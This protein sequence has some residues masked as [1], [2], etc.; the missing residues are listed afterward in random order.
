MNLIKVLIKGIE[1]PIQ[2]GNIRL[3]EYKDALSKED[4]TTVEAELN[5]H[6]TVINFVNTLDYRK[7][8]VVLISENGDQF[9]GEFEIHTGKAGMLLVGE[10]NKIKGIVKITAIPFEKR[11]FQSERGQGIA[12]VEELKENRN[13]L[14]A[15]F[16]ESLVKKDIKD[17]ENKLFVNELLDKLQNEEK[18]T[19]FEQ[20]L[21][22]EIN[23]ILDE[24]LV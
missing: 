16:L 15:H 6:P 4:E 9:T 19:A 8:Q 2:Q 24:I 17:Q 21:K 1:I 11:P 5:V 12:L 18:L 20:Y 10:P 7:E 3:I 13:V 22:S 14:F 23:Y